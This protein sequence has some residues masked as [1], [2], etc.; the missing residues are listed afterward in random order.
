M[1]SSGC[2]VQTWPLE[3][4][5][6]AEKAKCSGQGFSGEERRHHNWNPPEGRQGGGE[7]SFRLGV[8]DDEA[9]TLS[10]VLA[11]IRIVSG[12]SFVFVLKQDP[13]IDL[14]R[15]NKKF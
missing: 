3:C 14:L 10:H 12:E 2:N 8:E 11:E 1:H 6:S 15:V 4:Y 7:Q 9:P 13:V 5:L